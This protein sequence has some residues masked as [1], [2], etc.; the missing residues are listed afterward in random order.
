[1]T[2]PARKDN[3]DYIISL[4]ED[5][6]TTM[7]LRDSDL[8]FLS[9]PFD[10]LISLDLEVTLKTIL[11]HCDN[12]FTADNLIPTDL[13]YRRPVYANKSTGHLYVHDFT[14]DEGMPSQIQ[15]VKEKYGR[16]IK[17]LY[18]Y[19]SNGNSILFLYIISPDRD[20]RCDVASVTNLLNQISDRFNCRASLMIFRENDSVPVRHAQTI[21][22]NDVVMETSFC[23]RNSRKED[24]ID[25][26]KRIYEKTISKFLEKRF[27][28]TRREGCVKTMTWKKRLRI[29]LSHTFRICAALGLIWLIVSILP[30]PRLVGGVRRLSAVQKIYLYLPVE[31]RKSLFD[32]RLVRH[33]IAGRPLFDRDVGNFRDLGGVV[34]IDGRRIKDKLLY[35]SS[36][37]EQGKSKDDMHI[38]LRGDQVAYL[39]DVL[40]IRTELDLRFNSEYESNDISSIGPGTKRCQIPFEGYQEIDNPEFRGQLPLIFKIVGSSEN[41]PIVFHCQQ[42]QDRGGTLAFILSA[43][44]GKS[45]EQL[46]VDWEVSAFWNG[47]SKF[48]R[49]KYLKMLDFFNAVDGDTTREKVENYL[50]SCGVSGADIDNFRKIM[51]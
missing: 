26:R 20:Y 51:L 23:Y 4:G 44:L 2:Q 28:V 18:E 22:I 33:M 50:L 19:L 7:A 12:W 41:Y 1:M 9:L 10:W 49:K 6:R 17:R 5:C 32:Q 48:N 34:N 40:Q 37:F 13:K 39:R 47:G 42:G 36:A 25:G 35:R 21:K 31:F 3:F 15:A 45:D 38:V 46:Y 14:D 30:S 24:A 8:A 29:A 11:N 27:T 16:R 43:L